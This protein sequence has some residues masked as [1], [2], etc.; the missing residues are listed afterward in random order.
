MVDFA[1]ELLLTR[2]QVL[3]E[4]VLAAGFRFQH[5]TLE[6]L[7]LVELPPVSTSGRKQDA[8]ANLETRA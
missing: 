3:P 6:H 4:K 2:Q 1:R 8:A 7:L 5:P